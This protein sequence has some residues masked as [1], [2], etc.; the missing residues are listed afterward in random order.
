MLVR[1]AGS[2][3]ATEKYAWERGDLARISL[4]QGQRDQQQRHRERYLKERKR[5]LSQ[6]PSSITANAVFNVTD[7]AVGF[8]TATWEGVCRQAYVTT[9]L[10]DILRGPRASAMERR[11]GGRP[12]NERATPPSR[13]NVMRQAANLKDF[14]APPPYPDGFWRHLPRQ[15]SAR[16]ASISSQHSTAGVHGPFGKVMTD[17][18]RRS[19]QR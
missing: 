15:I 13:E 10:I 14:H 8:E 16:S 1:S 6:R 7:P 17:R 4:Q 2:Q 19:A 11:P 18:D 9:E 3:R 5:P 12:G